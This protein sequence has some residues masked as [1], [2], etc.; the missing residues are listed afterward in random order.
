LHWLS[1]LE[2]KKKELPNFSGQEHAH[3]LHLP[4]KRV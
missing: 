2:D 3:G 4:G 1:L